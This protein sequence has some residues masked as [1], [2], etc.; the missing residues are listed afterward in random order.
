MPCRILVPQPGTEPAPPEVEVQSLTHWT[1]RK[2]RPLPTAL[3]VSWYP[4]PTATSVFKKR[5]YKLVVQLIGNSLVIKII[6]LLKKH[7]ENVYTFMSKGCFLFVL[8]VSLE[9][10]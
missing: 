4:F 8:K 3:P 9:M 1:A 5:Y 6:I 7:M 10:V 2:V